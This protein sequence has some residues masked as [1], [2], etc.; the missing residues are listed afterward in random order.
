MSNTPIAPS[1][2]QACLFW[3]KLGCRSFGT[4]AGQIAMMY[5]ELIEKR[6]WISEN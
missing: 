4:L 2:W 6:Y 5:Q 1:T 3:L